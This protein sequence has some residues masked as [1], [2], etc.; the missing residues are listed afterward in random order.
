M[1][2]LSTS[3]IKDWDT[4]T[5]QEE[6]ITSL[7][8][9]ER[10][11]SAFSRWFLEHFPDTENATIKIF[12]GTGN[13]GGDGLAIARLLHHKCY[14]VVLFCCQISTKTTPDFNQNLKQLPRRNAI[15]IFTIGL[16]TP[17]PDLSEQDIVVDAL[18]GSGLNREITGYWASLIVH[19]NQS[20]A[21]KVAVD[22]PS[23]LYADQYTAG[24]ALKA[25]YTL[26]FQLPKLAFFFPENAEKIGTCYVQPIGLS[27]YFLQQTETPFHFIDSKLIAALYKSRKKFDHK[28][29]FGHALLIGGSHGKIG[30]I[31]LASMACLRSGA[32][33]VSIHAPQCAYTILQ[34]SVTEAMVSLDNH[35]HYY[36]NNPPLTRYRAIGIGCGL[37][38]KKISQTALLELIQISPIPLVLDADALNILS[39]NKEWLALLP[40]NSILTPHPKEFERLFGKSANDFERNQIQRVQAIKLKIFIILKGAHTCIACPDGTCYF[41]TTGNPGMGTGGSGDVLTGIITALVAQGYSSKDAALFGVYLHGLAGDLAAKEMGQ[42]SLIASD[43]IRFLGKGFLG[44]KSDLQ[45]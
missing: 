2:I 41:N 12:C 33:L 13:N 20:K 27:L 37:D 29:T 21:I 8:L 16:N 24:Q 34:I 17:F 36:S 7:Q 23:G 14:N 3:Q 31:H 19:I 35:Q 45:K 30:A 32:G 5:I 26:S 4:Y 43:I 1:K 22:I 40:A 28:G 15:P 44:M 42:E 6:S 39:N 10:A 9:M 38:Q 18:F 25:D 11:A